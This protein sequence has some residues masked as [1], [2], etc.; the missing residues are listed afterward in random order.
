MVVRGARWPGTARAKSGGRTVRTGGRVPWG[1]D[2]EYAY[3]AGYDGTGRVSMTP[4]VMPQVL[5][6]ADAAGAGRCLGSRHLA[7]LCC[8]DVGSRECAT[9]GRSREGPEGCLDGWTHSR[10][11][12]SPPGSDGTAETRLASDT[13]Q[14]STSMKEGERQ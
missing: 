8:Q 6:H 13:T 1:A 9:R 2:V 11:H 14:Q 10:T 12:G 4:V 7:G 5:C 3:R